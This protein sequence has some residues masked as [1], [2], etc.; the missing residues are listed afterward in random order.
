MSA[1][2][3]NEKLQEDISEDISEYIVSATFTDEGGKPAVKGEKY[4]SSKDRIDYLEK[5][6]LIKKA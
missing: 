6:G 3:K 4:E 5:M 1:K 2:Q